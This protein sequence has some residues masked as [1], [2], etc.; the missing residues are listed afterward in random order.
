MVLY[1]SVF[2]KVFEK[3]ENAD[4]LKGTGESLLISSG[5]LDD[6]AM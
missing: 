1:V 2:T 4:E 5:D 6:T 3:N